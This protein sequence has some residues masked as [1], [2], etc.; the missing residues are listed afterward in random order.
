MQNKNDTYK[1]LFGPVV[2]RRYG[3]SLGV[4]LVLPKT[5]SFNCIFC[6]I[7]ETPATTVTRQS[8]PPFEDILNELRAWCNSG[9]DADVITLA[10]SGEPTLHL[11]FGRVLSYVKDQTPYPSLLLSNGSLFFQ[12]DVRSQATD[13]DIVKLSLHAWDQTSFQRVTRA[14]PTLEFE[15]I[16][17]GYRRFRDIFE[18]RIELEVFVVPGINDTPQQ[19][20]RIAEVAQSFSPDSIFL[21]SAVRPPAESSVQQVHPAVIDELTAL[22]G[23]AAEGRECKPDLKKLP[24]SDDAVVKL[25]ARHP[26]TINQLAKQFNISHESLLMNLKKLENEGSVA[27]QIKEGETFVLPTHGTQLPL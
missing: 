16:V 8:K 9:N 15:K 25:T 7:G 6:Q 3:L 17:D 12:E 5:C 1:Y 19:M 22:F 20:E 27:L 21:N 18:G 14:D 24:Y 23:R 26:A 10:G 4:D 2:S 13:A 11:H